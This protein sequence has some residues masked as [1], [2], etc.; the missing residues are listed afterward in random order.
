MICSFLYVIIGIVGMVKMKKKLFIIIGILLFITGCDNDLPLTGTVVTKDEAVVKISYAGKEIYLNNF[1]DAWFYVNE[2]TDQDVEMTL[3]SDWV[4]GENGSF[5]TGT[6]YG[7]TGNLEP[8]DRKKESTRLIIDL[9]GHTIDRNLDTA[10]KAGNVMSIKKDGNYT[11]KNGLITGGNTL[12]RGGALWLDNDETTVNLENIT[13]SD[14]HA[15][16]NGGGIFLKKCDLELN[17]KDT[18]IINNSSNNYGGGIYI[19]KDNLSTRLS[20]VVVIKNNTGKNNR[21]NV[22]LQIVEEFS[23]IVSSAR[24]Y[25]CR[26]LLEGSEI[27]I[28]P[29]NFSYGEDMVYWVNNDS[30]KYFKSDSSKLEIIVNENDNSEKHLITVK[31]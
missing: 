29:S 13:I 18:T 5:G 9:N 25:S 20:G 26:D 11:I 17:I 31:K 24:I 21:N 15:D 8:V 6:G 2:I 16:G 3:Y 7:K 14:N 4:A 10:I 12:D 27:Y 30:D 28:S 19:S 22:T 23:F 1:T